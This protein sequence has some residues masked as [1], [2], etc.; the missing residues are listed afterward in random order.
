MTMNERV[1][2]L[3]VGGGPGGLACAADLAAGGVRVL[4]AERKAK[5]GAKVCAGGITWNGL[6]RL[7]PEALIEA[8]FPEQHI[9]TGRQRAVVAEANPIVATVNRER[10]GQWMA[11]RAAA[12]ARTCAPAAACC[13]WRAAGPPSR[14]PPAGKPASPLISSWAPTAPVRSCGARS[15]CL[16][17]PWGW[18]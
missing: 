9:V 5:I 11:Q 13:G 15:A 4:L 7:V 16:P 2:V 3:I 12:A 17:G 1:D 8:A 14:T 18:A 6:I 10:L